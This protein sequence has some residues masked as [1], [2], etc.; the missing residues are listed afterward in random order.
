V[1]ISKKRLQKIINEERARIVREQYGAPEFTP[2]QEAVIEAMGSSDPDMTD[3][4]ISLFRALM[5][6]GVNV[7]AVAMSS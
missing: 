5:E 2:E 6:A 3:Y 4:Y 7:N 1:K